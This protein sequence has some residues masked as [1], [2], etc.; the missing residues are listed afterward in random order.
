VSSVQV[1]GLCGEQHFVSDCPAHSHIKAQHLDLLQHCCNIADF[2]SLCEA[3]S[4][5][6]LHV[7]TT[8]LTV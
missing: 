7:G 1:V 3:C 5:T 8:L 6:T 4:E 2:M